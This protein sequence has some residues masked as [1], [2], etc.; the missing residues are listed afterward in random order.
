MAYH[1]LPVVSP[2]TVAEMPLSQ[3]ELLLV[4]RW[5]AGEFASVLHNL[6]NDLKLPEA[7]TIN[8]AARWIG[9]QPTP[10]E[11]LLLAQLRPGQDN[12]ME[13]AKL[14]RLYP[15]MRI[16]I[17]AGSWCEGELR[18]G[19]PIAG[20]IR[21]YWYEFP[22]WWRASLALLAKGK[23]PPWAEPLDDVRAGQLC[24]HATVIHDG[25]L[26]IDANHYSTFESLSAAL[27][28][29]GWSCHWQRSSRGADDGP[30][31]PS[32]STLAAGLWD[33]SQLDGAELSD[34]GQFCE[35]MK[36]G[37]ARVLALLDFP[38]P[39][40]IAAAKKVGANRILAKPYQVSLLNDEL[41]R[42][43]EQTSPPAEYP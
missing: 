26:I 15:L 31:K 17:V 41:I 2:A 21:L 14:L 27:T 19:R 3:P 32:G 43:S 7:A 6:F 11:I 10:P 38:R 24:P 16:I 25:R 34:L 23:A 22:A 4:G 42:L 20:V 37:S 29:F 13:I 33:G 9:H 40:H 36:A 35:H 18:T 12:P 8:D 30:Q 1:R 28:P 39:E 5:R